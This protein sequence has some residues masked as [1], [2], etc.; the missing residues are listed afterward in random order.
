MKEIELRLIKE[1]S[2]FYGFFLVVIYSK[3]VCRVNIV[4]FIK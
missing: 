4:G 2:D 1:D 3:F